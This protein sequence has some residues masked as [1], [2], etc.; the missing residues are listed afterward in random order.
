[1][2]RNVANVAV[3]ALDKMAAGLQEQIMSNATDED[4]ALQLDNNL[5]FIKSVQEVINRAAD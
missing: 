3:S 1:M 4:D 2:P 5:T